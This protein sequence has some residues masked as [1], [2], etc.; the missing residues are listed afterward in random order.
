MLKSPKEPTQEL[1]KIDLVEFE[2][3]EAWNK[4]KQ[5]LQKSFNKTIFAG[6]PK[7]GQKPKIMAKDRN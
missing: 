4:S 3:W 1:A 7:E 2:A 5:D 6:E